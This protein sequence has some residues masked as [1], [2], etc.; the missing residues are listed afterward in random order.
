MSCC[1]VVYGTVECVV[2]L[3]P[4]AFL[5]FLTQTVKTVF[6]CQNSKENPRTPLATQHP[7]TTICSHMPVCG[8]VNMSNY[9]SFSSVEKRNRNQVRSPLNAVHVQGLHLSPLLVVQVTHNC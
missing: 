1:E 3:L 4:R 6:C 5:K 8:W 7:L 2:T 9:K